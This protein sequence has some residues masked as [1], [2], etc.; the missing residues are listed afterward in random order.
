[1]TTLNTHKHINGYRV[2]TALSLAVLAFMPEP[3]LAASL[4]DTVK[5]GLCIIV[6][7]LQG[8]VGKAIATIAVLILGIGAFFGKV[9]WGI[10]IMFAVGI[11]AIFGAA[12]IAAEFGDKQAVCGSGA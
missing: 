1:M 6:K 10:A 9:N 2:A 8:D 12:E 4:S 3:A 11:V 5:D 7:A